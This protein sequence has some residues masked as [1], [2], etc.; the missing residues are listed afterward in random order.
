[1][2]TLLTNSKNSEAAIFARLWDGPAT[3]PLSVARYVIRLGF[4]GE[5]KARM[6]ELAARNRQGRLTAAETEELDNFIKAG[7]LLAIVQS[8]ARRALKTRSNSNTIK[9]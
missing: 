4:N 6:H 3:L 8:K 5:D 7:D 1:M 2:A 9:R